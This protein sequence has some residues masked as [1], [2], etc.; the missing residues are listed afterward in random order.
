MRKFI[1]LMLALLML[2]SLV[3]P[4]LA[5]EDSTFI[6]SIAPEVKSAVMEGKDVAENVIVTSVTEAK[7]Q[8]TE[9]SQEQRDLLVEVY[10]A[11]SDGS[12]KLPMEDGF[13]YVELSAVAYNGELTAEL[14]VEYEKEVQDEG[15]LLAYVYSEEEW[16]SVKSVSYDAAGIITCVY[17]E[18][19]PSAVILVNG[20]YEESAEPGISVDQIDISEDPSNDFVPSITCKDGMESS[21]ATINFAPGT[22]TGTATAEGIDGCVVVTSIAQA[23]DKSTDIS[24]EDR[25][26]LLEVYEKLS[27]GSMK[28]PLKGETVIKELVD[29]SFEY[30]DCRLIEEHGHKDEILKQEGVTLTVKFPM[31]LSQEEKLVVVSYVDG[32]WVEVESTVNADGTVTCV[33][34]DVCPVAFVLCEGAEEASEGSAPWT[35]DMITMWVIV[36]AVCAA[37]I[38]AV[39]VFMKKQRK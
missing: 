31:N 37:G 34:E 19:G 22:G 30:E 4:S 8:S 2:A 1:C 38:V 18:V 28:L 9:I 24:Q 12:M 11:L 35:G 32:Q 21:D 15:T 14:T 25:D 6:P 26:L 27:D 7:E 23:K 3:L 29:V 33:F 13:I 17:E 5:A 39:L 20:S 36:M 16:K 10:D